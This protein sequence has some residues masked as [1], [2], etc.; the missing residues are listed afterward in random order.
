MENKHN[1]KG[2]IDKKMVAG[3]LIALAAA[4][5]AAFLYGTETGKKKRKQIKSW[6][7]KAKADVL[8]K[9]ENLKEINEDAYNKI[10]DEVSEKY[11]SLKNI[12]AGEIL[13]LRDELKRQWKHIKKSLMP[14]KDNHTSKR[15][16]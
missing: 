9:I 2:K 6:S 10:V 5:G 7:L 4:T 14:A 15:K 11:R 12:D 13:S 16:K 8:E 3:G 1:R